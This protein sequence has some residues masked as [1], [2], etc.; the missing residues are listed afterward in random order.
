M[1]EVERLHKRFGAVTA[2]DDLSF[3][4]RPGQVTGFLGPNGAGKTTTLRIILGLQAPTGGTTRIGGREYRQIVRPLH[5]VGALLDAN[6]VHP[7]RSAYHHLLAIAHSNHISRCR[8]TEVLQLT[9]LDTVAH[10]RAGGFSLGMRQRLGIATAMLGDPPMLIFDEPVNGL[11]TDGILWIRQLVKTLAGEGRTVLVS[12]HLM[13]EMAQT[14]DQLIIIGR[15]RLLADTPTSAFVQ[16]SARADVVVRSPHATE[17]AQLVAAAGGTVTRQAD[18]ALAVTGVDAAAIGDLA[19]AN[20]LPVHALIPRQASLEDAYLD[21][22]ANAVE[23]RT[24]P[25]HD[26]E[27][28]R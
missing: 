28:R 14:A 21:I 2:V 8:I 3:T 12:S 11:D 26:P 1:I 4:V 6:A 19:A 17:L 24:R 25:S 20:G 18:G 15:G 22:T 16:A 5:Q 7:A 23:Y 27:P 13:T 9:G 10:R